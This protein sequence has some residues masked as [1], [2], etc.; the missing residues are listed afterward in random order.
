MRTLAEVRNT[1]R[2][3]GVGDSRSTGLRARSGQHKH[4]NA[5]TSTDHR[6]ASNQTATATRSL[7]RHNQHVRSKPTASTNRGAGA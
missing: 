5:R 6:N 4:D 2:R 1:A 3:P 7:Y